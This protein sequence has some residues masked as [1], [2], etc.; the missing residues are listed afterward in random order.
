MRSRTIVL[1]KC[2]KTK[3]DFP[4][5]SSLETDILVP[6]EGKAIPDSWD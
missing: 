4:S 2:G 3:S 5:P 1:L 6:D